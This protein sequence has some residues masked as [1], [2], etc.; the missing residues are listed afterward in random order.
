MHGPWHMPEHPDE[1]D[2]GGAQELAAWEAHMLAHLQDEC[3]ALDDLEEL[4]ATTH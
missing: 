3:P 4:H 2:D 1:G